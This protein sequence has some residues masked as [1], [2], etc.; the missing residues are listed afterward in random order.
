MSPFVLLAI[1]YA[2]SKGGKAAPYIPPGGGTI[3]PANL[4][5]GTPVTGMAT[6]QRYTL[7]VTFIGPPPAAPDFAASLAPNFVADMPAQVLQ[8]TDGS[9]SGQVTGVY[10]GGTVASTTWSILQIVT[11]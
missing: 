8:N 4:P 6:G 11:A 5:P 1:A 7:T 9:S 3:P 2:L 10:H